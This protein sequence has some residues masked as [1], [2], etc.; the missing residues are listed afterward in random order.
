MSQTPD[1]EL[2]R[3]VATWREAGP[4]LAARGLEEL[5]RLDT[6]EALRQMADLFE[7]ALRSAPPPDNVTGLVEQQ[8]L[9]QALRP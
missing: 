8:R 7:H 9:F 3:W 2:A 6:R 4:E 5:R 1:P